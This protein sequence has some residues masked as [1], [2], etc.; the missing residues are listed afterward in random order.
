MIQGDVW[1]SIPIPQRSALFPA[2]NEDDAEG[3][4]VCPSTR[5]R[6]MPHQM[7]ERGRQVDRISRPRVQTVVRIKF[8]G[9]S[10]SDIVRLP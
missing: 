5:P 7:P 8:M 10:D 4:Q 6:R 1:R 3:N 9:N 2:N